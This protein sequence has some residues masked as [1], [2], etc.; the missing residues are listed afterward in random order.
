MKIT[1]FGVA[2]VEG[3]THLSKWVEELR[4]LE[5]AEGFCRKFAKYIPDGGVVIDVGACL[6]DHTATY[7]RMVGEKGRVWAFEPNRIAFE[8]LEY[9][10]MR[11]KNVHTMQWALGD[12]S[13]GGF[14]IQDTNLGASQVAYSTTTGGDGTR[15]EELDHFD[16][17]MELTRLDFIKIDAEGWEPRILRGAEQTL[18]R[19]RPVVLCEINR[20]ILEKNGSSAE[21]IFAFMA[22][23]G[24]TVQAAEPENP[25]TLPQVDVLFLPK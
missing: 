19:F 11:F 13:F 22:G 17:V 18:R 23:L 14:T 16:D 7:A 20:P 12:R 25:I 10:M 8:C 4:T 3:D 6:G 21:E 2:V 9:N 15:V 1:F 5:V 24:Y